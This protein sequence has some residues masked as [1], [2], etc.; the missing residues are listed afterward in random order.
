MSLSFYKK[1]NFEVLS[2]NPFLLTD[3][4]AIIEV[5]ENRFARAGL[6]LYKPSWKETISEI[7]KITSVITIESGFLFTLP[8]G[9]YIYL[10][11]SELKIDFNL[12][13]KSFSILGNFA[14]MSLET[15]DMEK[16]IQILNI[17]EFKKTMGD[18]TQGWVSLTNQDN[19]TISLMAPNS[20]PHLFFNP[21]LTYFNGKENLSIIQKIRDLKIP[22]TEEITHF[23]KDN[24]VDNIIIRDNGGLGFFLFSD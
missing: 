13:N 3:G 23:N 24:V 21:S 5:N 1:L 2:S 8:S 22:I 10:I 14:G 6:K 7:K 16:S 4:K 12:S 11:E 9:T 17:L 15:T 19:F 18:A 20:C